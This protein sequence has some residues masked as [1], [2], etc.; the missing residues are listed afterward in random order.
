MVWNPACSCRTFDAS[1]SPANHWQIR[2]SIDGVRLPEELVRFSICTVQPRPPWPSAP[3]ACR[4][5]R[6]QA[7]S[8][9]VVR[10]PIRRRWWSI[11]SDQLCGIGEPGEI[12]IRTPFRTRG[13]LAG[14]AGQSGFTLNPF[15]NERSDIVYRT[16]DRG[17]YDLN[18]LLLISG[19]FDDQL[20]IRGNRVEPGEIAAVL[21]QNPDIR[22]SA[23]V[24]CKET[25]GE[26]FLVAYVVAEPNRTLPEQSDLRGWL[27]QSLPD[28]MIPA[29]FVRLDKL[30][31]TANGKLDRRAL[32]AR[33]PY[34]SGE[35]EILWRLAIATET[36]LA[37]LWGKL[38]RLERSRCSRRFLRV[39][40]ALINGDSAWSPIFAESSMSRFPC[41]PFSKIRPSRHWHA[42]SSPSRRTR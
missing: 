15:R 12:V 27:K 40:R 36:T 25:S 20:K 30:P 18:G 24:V 3:I 17:T 5:F 10:C 16:G 34:I 41:A 7:C 4:R 38:L 32:P 37:K 9:S 35:L 26:S 28:Y 1:S 31:L 22:Q 11:K 8:L 6:I 2:S 23:V 42:K 21:A 29:L 13:Y 14:S 39:G 33:T 19:R